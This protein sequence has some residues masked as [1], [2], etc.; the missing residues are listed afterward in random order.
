[1]ATRGRKTIPIVLTVDER[2]QRA[3]IVLLAAD[4]LTNVVIG[5]RVGVNH[6]T[7]TKWRRRFLDGGLDVLADE[8]RP[9]TP[10][11]FGDDAIEAVVVKTLTEKPVN[12]T[13]WSTWEMATATGMSQPTVARIWQDRACRGVA[14]DADR[15]ADGSWLVEL[16]QI[17]DADEVAPAIG[18]ALGVSPSPGLV[19]VEAITEW[20]RR[21]HVLL[22]LDNCEHVIAEVAQRVEDLLRSVP[23]V[24]ILTTSREPLSVEG[25]HVVPLGPLPVV[26]DV[27]GYGPAV[28]LFVGTRLRS[29]QRLRARPT[30]RRRH[31]SLYPPRRFAAD[32]GARGSQ[33]ACADAGRAAE[34]PRRPVRLLTGGRRTAAERHHTLRAAVEWSYGLLSP[35]EQTVFA[36]LSVFAGRFSL[37]DAIAI[38]VSD[39]LD[40]IDVVD[41][42]GRLTDYCLVDVGE[43]ELRFRLL[44]TLRAY[45]PRAAGLG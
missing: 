3:R 8:P 22:V 11:K 24:R 1:M 9:G 41:H 35:V 13:H 37:D 19:M 23:T 43:G 17:S 6:T 40:E 29:V 39:E 16:G 32:V 2:A 42:I 4:G 45:W 10:R 31:G 14:A 7:V 38:C 30:T 21:R 27:D 5:E 34:P 12:S 18:R 26:G 15:F 44:E 33:D 25:E 28:E 36:R 20:L